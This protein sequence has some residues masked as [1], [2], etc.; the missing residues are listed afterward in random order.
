MAREIYVMRNL[1]IMRGAR[2]YYGGEERGN[3]I[4]RTCGVRVEERN[5]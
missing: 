4:G 2:C 3:E 5:V 1:M